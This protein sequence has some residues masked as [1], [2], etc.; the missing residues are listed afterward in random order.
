MGFSISG[1]QASVGPGVPGMGL[2]S[3]AQDLGCQHVLGLWGGLL[4]WGRER[5]CTWGACPS[6]GSQDPGDAGRKGP[7]GVS[8]PPLLLGAET[9][10]AQAKVTYGFTQ[11]CLEGWTCP[12]SLVASPTAAP[13]PQ[14]KK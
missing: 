12:T 3:S 14:K 13:P 9:P 4:V 2:W 10:P 8:N 6:L 7:L 5:I 11:L 1:M